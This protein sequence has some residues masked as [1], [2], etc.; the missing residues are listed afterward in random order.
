VLNFELDR[1][2]PTAETMVPDAQRT[3]IIL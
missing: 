1:L 2:N 3:E